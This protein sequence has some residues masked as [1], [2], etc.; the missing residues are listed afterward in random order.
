MPGEHSIFDGE[1]WWP[2]WSDVPS[3]PL[4]PSPQQQDQSAL[5]AFETDLELGANVP[6]PSDSGKLSDQE[7]SLMA[8]LIGYGAS[9]KVR[10]V[11]RQSSKLFN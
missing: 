5:R 9:Q 11:W 2:K 7:P 6:L 10:L 8:F 3:L 4:P 1:W